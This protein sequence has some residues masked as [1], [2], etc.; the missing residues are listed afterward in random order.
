M[1]S[2]IETALIGA[3]RL[4][5]ANS[6][7]TSPLE[8]GISVIMMVSVLSFELALHHGSEREK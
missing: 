6:V 3:P 5:R 8:E 1:K 4:G 2:R 7:F